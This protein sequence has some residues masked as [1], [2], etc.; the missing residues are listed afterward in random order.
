[1]VWETKSGTTRIRWYTREPSADS[2]AGCTKGNHPPTGQF[3]PAKCISGSAEPRDT[4][5][6]KMKRLCPHGLAEDAGIEPTVPE[7]KSGA[8]PL[9]ES[10]IVFWRVVWDSNLTA[11][12]CANGCTSECAYHPYRRHRGGAYAPKR[13]GFNVF[14]HW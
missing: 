2:F 5:F 10:S 11:F 9:S 4:S 8:L 1:M 12:R 14:Q 7:S 6:L 3:L 13:L